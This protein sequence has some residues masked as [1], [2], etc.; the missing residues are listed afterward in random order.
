MRTVEWDV[1]TYQLRIFGFD[2]VRRSTRINNAKIRSQEKLVLP[3][4]EESEIERNLHAME[5]KK[6]RI[7]KRISGNKEE[8]E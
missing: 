8:H 3:R 5:P 7:M 6:R 1:Y 2:T 4:S